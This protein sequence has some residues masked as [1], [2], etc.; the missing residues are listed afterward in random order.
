MNMLP[1]SC[2]CHQCLTLFGELGQRLSDK[3]LS[4]WQF[5]FSMQIYVRATL[6]T[7]SVL[8]VMNPVSPV[9]GCLAHDN[10]VDGTW[11]SSFVSHNG[12]FHLTLW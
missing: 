7:K 8:C 12:N 6:N 4:F 2:N 5:Q 1:A 9:L 11:A 3:I 10:S